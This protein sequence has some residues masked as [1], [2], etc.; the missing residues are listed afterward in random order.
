LKSSSSI[1]VL[2]LMREA[3]VT[4]KHGVPRALVMVTGSHER[5]LG[6][7]AMHAAAKGGRRP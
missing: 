2:F 3:N 5:V 1:S 4:A 7:T 6:L